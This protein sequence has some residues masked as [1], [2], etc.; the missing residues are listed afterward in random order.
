M[1]TTTG[2]LAAR[3]QGAAAR[4]DL[5][6]AIRA[7]GTSKST[8]Y[9]VLRGGSVPSLEAL[10]AVARTLDV[11]IAIGPAGQISVIPV[12]RAVPKIVTTIEAEDLDEPTR[13]DES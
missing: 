3:L 9:R 5:P 12:D 7:A 6:E 1:T 8:V 10:A 11:W 13:P 4:L 2:E